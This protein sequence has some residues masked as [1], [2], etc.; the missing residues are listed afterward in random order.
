MVASSL[1]LLIMLW[2]LVAMGI[3]SFMGPFWSLPCTLLAG[4]SA[5]V[6]IAL[7]N[8]MG[9]IGGFV[10][11]YAMGAINRRTGS[12]HGGLVLAG[13]SLLLSATL[14]FRSPKRLKHTVGSNIA[15]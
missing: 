5:A 15:A 2:C 13:I 11:P 14:L 6:G 1:W 9:N 10:G 8:S 12:F 3:F 4:S 7:I